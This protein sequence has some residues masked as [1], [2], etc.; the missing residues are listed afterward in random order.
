MKETFQEYSARLMSYSADKDPLE[1]LASTPARI[2]A[3]IAGRGARE[4]HGS[5]GP[6]RWSVA[7][8]VTHLSDAEVVGAYRFRLV[9]AQSGTPLQA[10]DQ[11]DWAR[12]MKY[13]NRDPHASLLTL[14]EGLTDAELDRYGMHAERGKETVRAL[15]SLYAGHDL[16]HLGQ[17]E[18]LLAERAPE[19]GRTFTPGR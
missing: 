19:S 3:L 14:L 13:E 15:I 18:R 4:L 10:Y 1:V 5:P 2:G 16:N 12:E 7:Q 17:I 9:L 6:G 11:N 8:I